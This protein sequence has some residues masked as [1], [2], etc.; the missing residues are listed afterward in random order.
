MRLVLFRFCGLRNA[1]C[2]IV[3]S[4]LLSIAF[5]ACNS[6]RENTAEAQLF[7]EETDANR[8]T[9]SYQEPEPAVSKR[10]E[11]FNSEKAAEVLEEVLDDFNW[12][13]ELPEAARRDTIISLL[14]D[15]Y[16]QESY[17]PAWNTY[18]ISTETRNLLNRLE[19]LHREGLDTSDFQLNN[20][21]QEVASLF[22]GAEEIA[23][24]R[25]ASLD[26]KLS[27][28]YLALARQL[29]KGRI[30][31]GK[32]TRNWHIHPEEVDKLGNLRSALYEGLDQALTELEPD[33]RQYD[34]LK[35]ALHHYLQIA[36]DGGW[37]PVAFKGTLSLGDSASAI[38]AIRQ[39]LSR[40]FDLS[41]TNNPHYDEELQEVL[42]KVYHRYGLEADTEEINEQLIQALN[43]PVEERIRLL[44]LN[45]ERCRWL[46]EPMGERYLLVNLPEYKLRLVEEGEPILDMKVIVGKVM[47]S[48]PIFS[49][50]LEYVEFSPY[51]NVPTSI[52]REEILP[53]AMED[54]SYLER[55]NYELVEYWHPDA[56][57]IS[58]Y[59]VDWED[60]SVQEFPYRVRQKPGPWNALGRVKFMFPN[61][62]AIYLHDTPDK[63]LFQKAER[64][65]SHGC[66]RVEQPNLL[67]QYLLPELD[68][69]QIAYYMNRGK[70]EAIPLAEKIPVYLVY[71]TTVVD[72]NG[73]LRFLEDIYGIDEVQQDALRAEG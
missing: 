57:V 12:E 38:I 50:S 46:N 18:S 73:R 14:K 21:R 51:W 32:H 49:D 35:Q 28:H 61:S 1:A 56:K 16:E 48:T 2:P 47:N 19:N 63:K 13:Q 36:A 67:A 26:I 64:G 52:A 11:H 37:E 62:K 69:E 3:F 54:P 10:K 70:R 15:F 6:G 41:D 40:E 60:V 39:R 29:G 43:V 34:L 9:V 23:Y 7:G 42:Q 27:A 30:E 24:E 72:S 45:L 59:E 25:L 17:K 33:Y 8:R 66:I 22:E 20:L 5:A 31:P 58:P 71:F 4:L 53:R 68:E 44:N 55:R 65:F